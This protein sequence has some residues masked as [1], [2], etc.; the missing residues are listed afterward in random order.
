MPE[1]AQAVKRRRPK[2]HHPKLRE[3]SYL[4]AKFSGYEIK[5]HSG[6]SDED[7]SIHFSGSN[8]VLLHFNRFCPNLDAD[9]CA[10]Q[11]M[12]LHLVIG[13]CHQTSG[14]DL[15]NFRNPD[16]WANLHFE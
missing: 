12:A 3:Q 13:G 1:M 10:E 14:W 4:L 6:I 5:N 15:S 9:E 2:A 16:R 8:G 11:F 7:H